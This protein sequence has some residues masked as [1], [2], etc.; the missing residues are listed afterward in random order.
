MGSAVERVVDEQR[1]HQ[2][3]LLAAGSPLDRKHMIELNEI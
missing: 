2:I 3:A 1:E